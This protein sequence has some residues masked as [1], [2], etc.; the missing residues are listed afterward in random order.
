MIDI[1]IVNWNSG[2]YLQKCIK[3]LL[4]ETNYVHIY[5]IFI[6]D[7]NS[8]DFSL[9]KINYSSKIEIIKN[10]ENKG[11]S[12][13]CNQGFKLCKSP[14]ILLLNPDTQLNSETLQNCLSFMNAHSEI[15]ILGCQLLDEKGNVSLSCCRFPTPLRFFYD[16][17]GLS[18]LFPRIFTPALLMSDWNHNTSRVVD[19]VM[20]AFMF[21]RSSVFK[22]IGYFD[23]RFFVYYEELDF[24]KRLSNQGGKSYFDS[25]ITAIHTGGGTTYLIKTFRLFLNLRSRLQY[26]KKHFKYSGYIF[27]WFSTFFIEPFTRIFFS[28]FK[29]RLNEIGEVTRGYKLLIKS[30]RKIKHM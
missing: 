17:S 18:K 27:V 4:I 30:R 15:D 19:Q 14:Y 5:N 11:F 29:L 3:S 16:A 20:G 21:M 25:N 6:I 23:E 8:N 22:K 28:L 2:N 10:A 24:S 9:N 1:V 7:N 26:S 13:A 12:K